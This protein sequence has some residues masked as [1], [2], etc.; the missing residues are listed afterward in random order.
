[1]GNKKPLRVYHS[2]V[3][4]LASLSTK[5]AQ[6]GARNNS[7]GLQNNESLI[8]IVGL[9]AIN[10]LKLPYGDKPYSYTLSDIRRACSARAAANDD[11]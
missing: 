3:R 1:M 8:I 4:D 5:A 2:I 7:R 11:Y 6:Q 10:E 9:S